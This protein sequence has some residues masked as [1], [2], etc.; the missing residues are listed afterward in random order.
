VFANVSND[1]DALLKALDRYLD[2]SIQNTQFH[3]PMR[4]FIAFY[5]SARNLDSF[6]QS[7]RTGE[8]SSNPQSFSLVFSP[9]AN[10]NLIGTGIKAPPLGG[11]LGMGTCQL[12][13]ELY[14]LG[15][16]S[17]P[18]GYRFAFTPIRKV[19]RLC[20]QLF[21]IQ[22]GL[23]GASASEA[24]FIK[25]NELGDSLGLDPT[26]NHCFDLPLQI[27]AEY[28]DVRTEV[29]KQDFEAE[30][31]DSPELDAAPPRFTQ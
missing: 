25:L 28:K 7:I 8:E 16:L 26:F 14:R 6:L 21:G 4:Q 24:I 11:M 20:T 23:A 15:R 30:A 27:L 18:N 29:L 1:P 9:N 10:P 12:L 22:D 31:M 2:K 3:F 5:A 17:N 13:R 19:R